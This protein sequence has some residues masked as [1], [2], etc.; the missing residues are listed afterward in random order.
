MA[1]IKIKSLNQFLDNNIN[2]YQVPVYQRKYT[3]DKF[4]CE[5]FLNDIYNWYRKIQTIEV[6]VDQDYYFAGSIITFT[7]KKNMSSIVDGQQRLTTTLLILCALKYHLVKENKNYDNVE[8]MIFSKSREL[9]SI[10]QK[11]LKLN[12]PKNDEVLLKISNLTVD[13]N[14]DNLLILNFKHLIGVIEKI[15]HDNPN[16]DEDILESLKFTIMSHVILNENDNPTEIFET[17][18]TTGKKL[19][20]ADMIKNY[21]FFFSYKFLEKENILSKKYDEIEDLLFVS[22]KKEKHDLDMMTFYRYFNNIVLGDDLAKKESIVIFTQ[23]KEIYSYDKVANFESV[24]NIIDIIKKHAWIWNK[25]H[26]YE[27]KRKIDKFYY[28]SFKDTIYTYYSLVHQ[29]IAEKVFINSNGEFDID[30]NYLRNIFRIISKLMFS[31]LI[32]GKSEKNITRDIPNIYKLFKESNFNDFEKWMIERSKNNEGII[33]L[34][35][36]GIEKY[37]NNTNVYLL[38]SKKTKFLLYGIEGMLDNWEIE[39]K[40]I[41]DLSVEH[42]SPQN[43]NKNS[44]Y[45]KYALHLANNNELEAEEY[46]ERIKHKLPNLTLVACETNSELSNKSYKEK[47]MIYNERSFLSI[48]KELS[49]YEEWNEESIKKRS[50]WLVEQIDN[51]LN[52]S[53]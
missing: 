5:K 44:S 50:S 35:K 46:L 49:K 20:A 18:N 30:E 10:A 3:W 12:N 41:D 42:I 4:D 52:I 48:N 36:E 40:K 38:S 9:D 19:T 17:I 14:S 2:A 22:E 34:D 24:N 23:F 29:L 31:L 15:K 37:I 11:K 28:N 8:K 39:I 25:I 16:Y 26:K 7:D 13:F 32:S 27:P 21:L 51:L 33:I 45:F 47:F 6:N 53:N 1:G 43:P